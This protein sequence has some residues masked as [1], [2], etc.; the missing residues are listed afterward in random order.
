MLQTEKLWV[1]SWYHILFGSI[2]KKAML[3]N[4]LKLDNPTFK[5]SRFLVSLGGKKNQIWP[6]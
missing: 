1:T 3:V 4:I 6:Q 2:F 5:K